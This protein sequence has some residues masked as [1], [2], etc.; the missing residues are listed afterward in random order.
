MV[1]ALFWQNWLHPLTYSL[2]VWLSLCLSLSPWDWVD[3]LESNCRSLTVSVCLSVCLSSSSPLVL[4][5][6]PRSDQERYWQ[7][8]LNTGPWHPCIQAGLLTCCVTCRWRGND[9]PCFVF[10]LQHNAQQQWEVIAHQCGH[11]E[12]GVRLPGRLDHRQH[13]WTQQSGLILL[14]SGCKPTC[15]ALPYCRCCLTVVIL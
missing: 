2:C 14:L 1:W 13:H 11:P 8:W 7:L 4:Y 15:T 12:H 3:G 6:T 9:A 5:Q 10:Q